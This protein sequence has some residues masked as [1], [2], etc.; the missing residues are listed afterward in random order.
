MRKSVPPPSDNMSSITGTVG[1]AT[2]TVAG[3]ED[4][5]IFTYEMTEVVIT[6]IAV[7]GGGKGDPVETVK[8]DYAGITWKE[9]ESNS[10][11]WDRKTNKS[12]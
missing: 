7:S 1:T 3:S 12:P 2:L 5:K 9:G 8:L 11:K 4:S 10:T 6:A